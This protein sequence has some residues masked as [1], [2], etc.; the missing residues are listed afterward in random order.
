MSTTTRRTMWSSLTVVGVLVMSW[1]GWLSTV[2]TTGASTANSADILSRHNQEEVTSVDQRCREL[3]KSAG[4]TEATL[5]F[6]RTDLQEI[7]QLLR[8]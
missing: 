8:D 3:E 1:G 4:R 6:M 5:E 2:A 7:K